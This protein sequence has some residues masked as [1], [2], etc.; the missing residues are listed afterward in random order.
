MV[1]LFSNGQGDLG[2]IPGR[3]IPKTQKMVLDASLL[4][5]QHYKLWIKGKV[6]NP[7]KGVAPS[8]TSWCSSYW[9]GNLQVTIIYNSNTEPYHLKV[10]IWPVPLGRCEKKGMITPIPIGTPL[11]GVD[12]W[13]SQ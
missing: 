3:I 7:G 11:I 1:R 2:S 13:L 9:K 10:Q 4:N 6:G 8:P 12:P 5:T